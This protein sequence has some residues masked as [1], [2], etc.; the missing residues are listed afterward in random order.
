MNWQLLLKIGEQFVPFT[1]TALAD[2]EAIGRVIAALRAAGF[3][4][5]TDALNA[6]ITDDD[7]REAISRAIAAN[8]PPQG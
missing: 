5:D 3:Q 4:E 1:Q 6:A 8:T 7:R 2:A